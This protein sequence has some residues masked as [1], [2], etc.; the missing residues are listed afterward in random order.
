MNINN[1][2]D[3]FRNNKDIE[4]IKKVIDSVSSPIWYMDFKKNTLWVS[5]EVA[6]IYGH[7]QKDFEKNPQLWKNL[8]CPEDMNLVDSHIEK[9]LSG[10][11]SDTEYR[12]IRSDGV[13][14]WV[15]NSVNIVK[16]KKGKVDLTLGILFDITDQKTATEKLGISQNISKQVEKDNDCIAFYD[17]LT[18]LPNRN[19]LHS[20]LPNELTGAAEKKQSMAVLMIDLDRFKVINDSLGHNAGDLLLKEVTKRLKSS[21]HRN[22]VIFRHS[23]DEFIIVL[24]DADK[25]I[26]SKVAQRVLNVLAGTYKIENHEIF[27][28]SSIGI[29]LF[30]ENGE[31]VETLIKHA[32]FAMYQAKKAGKNN[33]QFYLINEHEFNPLQMEV[34]LYKAIEHDE[35]L[36]HY[37]PKISLKT[38]NILGVEAL[39]RWNHPESGMI[40]PATFIPISEETGLIIPIGEWVLYT[41]CK[42]NKA[43]QQK[44]F[45]TV[46]AVNISARQF[47]QSN[48]VNLVATILKETGLKPQYLELEITES[49]TTD[50]EC[51]ISTLQQLKQLGV[52]ISIDDFGTGFSSLNYLKQFPIDTLKIDQ[53]FVRGLYNNPNDETIVKT[54]ISMAH[55]LH[56]NVVAEGIETKEQ[57][58]FLQQHLC[59]EGQGYF[60]SKPLLANELEEVLQ[61][62]QQIVKEY[63]VSQ[64]IKDRMWAEELIQ[65]AKKEIQD[66]VR[67]QQGMIFKYKKI[68]G[69]FIHTLCD[70]DLMYRLGLIPNQVVGKTVHEF[71]PTESAMEKTKYYQRAWEGEELVTYESMING[72]FYLAA[73]R[74]I[75]RSGE[76]IEVIGSCVDI[77]ERKKVEEALR[78]SEYKYRLITENM[79]DSIML[80]DINGHV[81]YASPSNVKVIGFSQKDVVNNNIIDR[82]HPDDVPLLL[83]KFYQ[84]GKTKS[85]LQVEFRLLHDNGYWILM[86]CMGTPVI[87]GN[88]ETEHIIVVGRDITE[89][90]NAEEQLSKTEKLTVVGELAAGVAHE[91]RNPLTSIRGLIQL[92]QQGIIKQEFFE[93]I[94]D[95]FNRLEDI[96]KEFLNLAQPKDIQI[97]KINPKKL[98]KDVEILMESEANLQNVQIF[99]Q[100]E[101]NIPLIWCDINQIKQVLINLIKNSIEAIHNGGCVNIQ[102]IKEK[103]NV[104]IKIIDNGVGINEERLKKLGE[105]FFSNKEKG[106]GLGLMLCLRIISL[107]KGTITF[108]SEK[109]QGTTVEIR[110]P[111]C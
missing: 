50:I 94:Y 39:I 21:I 46:M 88:G 19:M 36:L 96:I 89:K 85:P 51:T 76:V 69:Q 98:L 66:T 86:E 110:L 28:T 45:K 79:T 107:H 71:L 58:V 74:P 16:N 62:I 57:L 72:I 40:S 78:E 61:G 20:R 38:G 90:R 11:S 55:N 53:S 15:Q 104:L 80:F 65:I 49:M 43:W 34:D 83:M 60:F 56:L 31:T 12:I 24:S 97:K 73:L 105:P 32:D 2:T 17:Y 37:Q 75:K 29:S 106:T 42:Q 84:I 59:N 13:I 54:I 100:V 3:L 22:D 14:R 9:L 103:S 63:G 48:F 25:T 18:G 109:N 1:I 6:K 26:A 93:V 111:L 8:V 30:P 44:G 47:T 95:E 101:P 99:S 52:R 87:G 41:A 27:N 35:F 64:D 23:G 102:A 67:L 108:I 70:G 68:S 4:F 77:T 92:L 91:I 5:N 10:I 82:I 81:L 7:T 33:Y